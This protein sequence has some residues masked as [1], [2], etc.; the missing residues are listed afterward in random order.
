MKEV[1]WSRG[2]TEDQRVQT[3]QDELLVTVQRQTELLERIAVALERI[4]APVGEV[5]NV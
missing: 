4:S 3:L 1:G 2:L 5:Y